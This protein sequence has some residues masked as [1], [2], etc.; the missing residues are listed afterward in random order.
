MYTH[1]YAVGSAKTT[2]AKLVSGAC[3]IFN[4]S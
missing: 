1:V 2:M 3:A 4:L